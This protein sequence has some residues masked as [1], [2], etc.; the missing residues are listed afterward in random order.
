M[1]KTCVN[2]YLP[3]YEYVPDGEPHVFGDRLYIFGSH[4]RFGGKVYCEQD[5]VCWSAPVDDLSDWKYEGVIY[6]KSQDPAY[7]KGKLNMW[8]PDVC[9]G[10]DGKYYL[11]YCGALTPWI[12]VARAD[13]PAGPYEYY[14]RVVHPDGTVYG[15]KKDDLAFDPSVLVDTDGKV[16]LY[17][18]VS[19]PAFSFRML[20]KRVSGMNMLGKGSFVMELD[21]DMRTIKSHKP[22]LPGAKNSQGTGFEGHEFFEAS[23]MRKIGSKYYYIYSSILSHEL[24]YAVSDYPD[25]GFVYQ[26]ALHSNGNIGFDGQKDPTAYWG[27]NHGSVECINGE[28]YIFGHRQ[29]NGNEVCRQ[30]VAE[31]LTMNPDGTFQM[32]GMTSCGLNGGPLPAEGQYE[33]GIAC[34]LMRKD[35]AHKTTL[36]KKER[37]Q[38]PYITQ[39]GV[40]RD[41]DPGQYIGNFHDNCVAGYKYFEVTSQNNYLQVTFR[42]HQNRVGAGKILVSSDMDFSNVLAEQTVTFTGNDHKAA[43]KLSIKPGV[44]ALYLKYQ[45]TGSMDLLTISFDEKG[46]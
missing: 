16:W 29:T 18:G 41:S 33:A 6:R 11:Y 35:G 25:R 21:Q 37:E 13:K 5:Y 17:T 22:C 7:R 24:A 8:A 1:K 20:V 39:D 4:D 28:Y 36:C 12:G 46:E 44:Y 30:G 40:D 27:N 3:S 45:G 10:A 23:S 26:G 2:P 43:M 15:R 32:A 9:R 31:K 14:G 38:H 34:V 19:S 42:T